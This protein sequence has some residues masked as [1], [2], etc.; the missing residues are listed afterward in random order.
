MRLKITTNRNHDTGIEALEQELSPQEQRAD[1][2]LKLNDTIG[3][4]RAEPSVN[5]PTEGTESFQHKTASTESLVIAG[6]IAASALVMAAI[7]KIYKH[8]ADKPASDNAIRVAQDL[9]DLKD[10]TD[11]NGG[12]TSITSSAANSGHLRKVMA[13][14]LASVKLTTDKQGMLIGFKPVHEFLNSVQVLVA[15][16]GVLAAEKT[17][18][19]SGTLSKE[20]LDTTKFETTYNNVIRLLNELQWKMPEDFKKSFAISE[21]KLFVFGGEYNY[22]KGIDLAFSELQTHLA[23]TNDK[24]VVTAAELSKLMLSPS[25]RETI[26]QCGNI[27]K[28]LESEGEAISKAAEKA[29]TTIKGLGHDLATTQDDIELKKLALYVEIV[30]ATA[31]IYKKQNLITIAAVKYVEEV[32]KVMKAASNT[33]D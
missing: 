21:P 9:E 7:Y 14:Y 22:I 27:S 20:D 33:I 16:L 4:L 1:E 13:L 5:T 26:V 32:A 19:V 8:F 25:L 24:D 17:G 3:A 12:A 11:L 23:K 18:T 2:Y 15:K 30:K 10:S 31:N 28:T 6:I 29:E